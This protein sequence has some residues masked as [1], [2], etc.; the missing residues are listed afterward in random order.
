LAQKIPDTA[1]T[2]EA[3]HR[4]SLKILNDFAIEM[5]SIADET[6]LAWHVAREVVG[7]L[8]FVDCV[9]YFADN[10]KNLLRQVAATGEKNPQGNEL[11]SPLVI[12]VGA[13]VTGHVAETHQALIIDD[14][15][16]DSRYIPDIE[17]A[18]SEIC[19]P[20][21]SGDQILGVIDCEDPRP[22]HFGQIHLELLTTVSAMASSRMD[23]LRKEK[24]LRQSE[25]NYRAIV[26]DQS[27]MISRHLPDGTRTYVN[28]SYCRLHSK[29][30]EQLLGLSAY[31][32]METDDLKRLKGLYKTL[33]PENPSG[34]FETSF[35]GSCGGML[36]Q[37]WTKRAIF[38]ETGQVTEY[39]AVGHD[40]TERKQA[41][42]GRR[43]A[44]AEA[45][46]ANKA[47]SEFLAAMSHELRTP[48]N[49][50]LGFAEI[51]MREYLGPIGDRKYAEYATDIHSSGEYLLSLVNDLL[52][53][54]TIE[55]GKTSLV[56]EQMEVAEVI[57]ESLHMVSDKA[58]ENSIELVATETGPLPLL[59]ADRRA[60]RQI[61]LNLLTNALKFT[62]EGGTVTVSATSSNEKATF[63]IADTGIGIAA[64]RL[65]EVTSPFTRGEKDPYKSEGWGLGLA[66]TK[67][68]I[69]LHDGDIAIQ[70]E[71]GK[72]TTV[73][74]EL[75][76]GVSGQ[77][78]ENTLN[79]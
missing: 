67:S 24:V 29:S 71:L 78:P 2:E 19:V 59:F 58:A 5:F 21:L 10:D 70:S 34:V 69:D 23:L 22:G 42:D 65:S 11:S 38:D 3:L 72:G 28:E 49:A 45:E 12:P 6:E 47:K 44:L 55:A 26:E 27:E 7:K 48:L 13:G 39:Q 79:S 74:V 35:R 73:K 76:V 57:A 36:W 52:D 41:E 9:V 20:L 51:L 1:D 8:G 56:K 68:L 4:A 37:L 31:E 15:S 64:D 17:P 25:K 43:D 77:L 66:I 18:L 60:I 61:L 32:G 40:I 53:I 62:P 63:T 46:T 50:I 16:K 54:S 75:P 33:T 30:R 14:L